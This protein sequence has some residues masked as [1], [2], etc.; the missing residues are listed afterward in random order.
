M[1]AEV[2]VTHLLLGAVQ[3][4]A[5]LHICIASGTQRAWW[6]YLNILVVLGALMM[7]THKFDILLTAFWMRV[8]GL[9]LISLEAL[10]NYLSW[11]VINKKS[12]RED[13]LW[14]R[15]TSLKCLKLHMHANFQ[16]P[17]TAVC[18]VGNLNHIYK[19]LRSIRTSIK[20]HKQKLQISL[21]YR[22]ANVITPTTEEYH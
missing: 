13:W 7:N 10:S 3:C 19:Q 12:N 16:L 8:L 4:S 14:E 6:K 2:K 9:L 1:A 22:E 17:T 15:P 18:L 5:R 21:L 11:N 20:S